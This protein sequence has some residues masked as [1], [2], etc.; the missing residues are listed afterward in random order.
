MSYTINISNWHANHSMV[1]PF[2]GD[3]SAWPIRLTNPRDGVQWPSWPWPSSKMSLDVTNQHHCCNIMRM[4]TVQPLNLEHIPIY[5]YKCLEYWYII[6]CISYI[7]LSLTF[8]WGTFLCTT[9]SATVAIGFVH[10]E[11]SSCPS[12]K[13][14]RRLWSWTFISCAMRWWISLAKSE[15]GA[16]NRKTLTPARLEQV[17]TTSSTSSWHRTSICRTRSRPKGRWSLM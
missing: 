17:R 2:L 11:E 7:Y 9:K 10:T 13:T 5:I 8:L 15:P 6:F 14:T 1:Y 12:C 4:A 3:Q 16:V